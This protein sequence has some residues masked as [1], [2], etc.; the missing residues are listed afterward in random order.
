MNAFRF[1]MLGVSDVPIGFAWA[2]MLAS[3]A[4]LFAT[5]VLLLQRGYRI[6]E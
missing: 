4:V 5:C 3:L 1:G 6:R 2:M